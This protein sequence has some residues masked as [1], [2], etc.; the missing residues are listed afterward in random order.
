MRRRAEAE[1]TG[2]QNEDGQ[3]EREKDSIALQAQHMDEIKAMMREVNMEH[4]KTDTLTK[5]QGRTGGI[6]NATSQKLQRSE[7]MGNVDSGIAHNPMMH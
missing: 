4:D 2:R 6:Q 7:T 1:E 3:P 5:P